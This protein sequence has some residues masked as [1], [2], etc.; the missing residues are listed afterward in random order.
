MA[1]PH[2]EMQMAHLLAVLMKA[3]TDATL[4]VYHVLR[5]STPKL[6]A[7]KSAAATTLD[8]RGIEYVAAAITIFQAAEAERNA[9][10]HA[11]WGN[12]HLIKDGILWLSEVDAVHFHVNIPK[13]IKSRG[14]VDLQKL[15]DKIFFYKLKDLKSIENQIDLASSSIYVLKTY[16]CVYNGLQDHCTIDQICNLI[17]NLEP[18]KTCLR[19]MRENALQKNSGS[20]NP[21]KPKAA[22]ARQRD[23][24]MKA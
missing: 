18:M 9:L 1:W 4:A 20:Q 22:R 8:A 5:R 21:T 17:E 10:A 2:L 11:E 3:D 16:V 12:S 13:E 14:F 15:S 6:D 24:R 19:Q 23:H 7:I